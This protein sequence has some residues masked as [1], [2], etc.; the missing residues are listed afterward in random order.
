[1]SKDDQ[2]NFK[3]RKEGFT[4]TAGMSKGD[5]SRKFLKINDEMYLINKKSI[6]RMVMADDTDPD[7]TNDSIDHNLE[8]IL[9]YGFD[10]EIVNRTLYQ[11]S[12]LFEENILSDDIDY[13]AGLEIAFSFMKEIL[14]LKKVEEEYIEKEKRVNKKMKSGY[15]NISLIFNLE[16][17]IKNFITKANT[18]KKLLDDLLSL[19]HNDLKSLNNESILQL[20]NI[21]LYSQEELEYTAVHSD[22][23]NMIK[24]MRDTFEHMG[25]LINS[26]GLITIEDDSSTNSRDRRK[27][28]VIKNYKLST[29]NK[30]TTPNIKFYISADE[31]LSE[32]INVF[33]NDTVI[34]LVDFFETFMAILCNNH[35]KDFGGDKRIVVDNNKDGVRFKYDILWT[36]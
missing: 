8:D 25:S 12:I 10:D 29:D 11:A 5:F 36:K 34:N 32:N 17:D 35:T 18:I 31:K 24:K 21:G 3:Y 14:E 2:D 28:I 9:E 4:F 23:L 20:K 13:N 26:N 30:I 15:K 6:Q 19:F 27:K 16:Q 1:M 7:R 22:Y 33:I